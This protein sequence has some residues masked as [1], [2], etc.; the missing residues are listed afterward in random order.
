[1]S[2]PRSPPQMN[3]A[4]SYKGA[5]S[6]SL[7]FYSGVVAGCVILRPRCRDAFASSDINRGAKSCQSG[8]LGADEGG[9]VPQARVAHQV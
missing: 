5:C 1:M 3:I 6:P 2:P 4:A 7:R 8:G 9:D